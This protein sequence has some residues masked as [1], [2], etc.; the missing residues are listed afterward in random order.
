MNQMTRILGMMIQLDTISSSKVKVKDQSSR[1]Q[2]EIKATTKYSEVR[3][4]NV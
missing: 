4:V 3:A 2:D 1:S